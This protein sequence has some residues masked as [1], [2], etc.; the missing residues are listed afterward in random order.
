MLS[1]LWKIVSEALWQCFLDDNPQ[2][3]A[4]WVQTGVLL[5]DTP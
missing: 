4:H 3:A 2:V 5:I 1:H